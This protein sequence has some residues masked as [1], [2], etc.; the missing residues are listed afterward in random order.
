LELIRTE[1]KRYL[2]GLIRV[3]KLLPYNTCLRMF[4]ILTISKC[5][6]VLRKFFRY[7]TKFF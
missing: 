3:T 6:S 1:Q 4:S 2:I 5:P 7:L